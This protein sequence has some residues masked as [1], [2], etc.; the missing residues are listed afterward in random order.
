MATVANGIFLLFTVII[1]VLLVR[2][3]SKSIQEKEEHKIELQKTIIQSQEAEREAIANNLHD[4]FGPQLSLLS[5]KLQQVDA[6]NETML[7]NKND[8]LE[9]QQRL[10][11]IH[12]DVRKYSHDIFPTQLKKIG[13]LPSIENNVQALTAS[14][15]VHF[16]NNLSQPLNFDLATE[17]TLYRIFNEVLNNFIKHAHAQ[18]LDVEVSVNNQRFILSLTHDGQA[19]PQEAFLKQAQSGEGKGCASILNRTRQL[20]GSIEFSSTFDHLQQI[21]LS[22]PINVLNFSH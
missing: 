1:A 3:I 17:L 4:D 16:S 21:T 22:I 13:L 15:T 10:E 8:L 19:F 20:N 5:R 11:S 9:I 7:L 12:H 18:R 6:Q 2:R 14:H